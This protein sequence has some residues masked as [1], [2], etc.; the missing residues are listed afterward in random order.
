LLLAVIPLIIPTSWA[1]DMT[2]NMVK[3]PVPSDLLGGIPG[4]VKGSWGTNDPHH[5]ANKTSL[6]ASGVSLGIRLE[7]YING[8]GSWTFKPVKVKPGQKYEYLVTYNSTFRISAVETW[9]RNGTVIDF[10]DDKNAL[11]WPAASTW[12]MRGNLVVPTDYNYFAFEIV[13]PDTDVRGKLPSDMSVNIM[14][15]VLK[16]VDNSVD[17]PPDLPRTN[18]TEV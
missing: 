7:N 13:L 17:W 6:A 5:F 4:W 14:N 16:P 1:L 8:T 12:T 3:N 9:S 2:G 18:S 11:H 15:V 10:S